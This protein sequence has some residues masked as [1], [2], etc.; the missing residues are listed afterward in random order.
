[1]YI[2]KSSYNL[3]F[4]GES[5]AFFS[6]GA[7]FTPGLFVDEHLD[8][9]RQYI[10]SRVQGSSGTRFASYRRLRPRKLALFFGV[11]IPG[12]GI[13]V[14]SIFVMRS[15]AFFSAVA[16]NARPHGFDALSPLR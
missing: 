6:A 9:T 1:M 7:S 3:V 16:G 15:G 4:L 12:I 13:G 8:G 14:C 2:R 10:V 5:G 11:P